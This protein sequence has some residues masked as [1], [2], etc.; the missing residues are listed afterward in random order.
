MNR[1]SFIASVLGLLA[2]RPAQTVASGVPD[3][4]V[5]E[6]PAFDM[7][8]TSGYIVN[9]IGYKPLG[10]QEW[11][12]VDMAGTKYPAPG[13]KGGIYELSGIPWGRQ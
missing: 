12:W 8:R 11:C 1:R 5:A 2:I 4:V 7:G 9:R 3:Y 6:S 10:S 13:L